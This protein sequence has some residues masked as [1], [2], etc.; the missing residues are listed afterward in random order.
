MSKN[1]N[2]LQAMDSASIN[3]FEVGRPA[4][5]RKL[6]EARVAVAELIEAT[7]AYLDGRKWYN[8]LYAN[9]R[10]FDNFAAI[11]SRFTAALVRVRGVA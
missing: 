1:V 2:V 9:K 3:L 7:T 6:D 11:E 8:P 5:G 4:D 10:Q